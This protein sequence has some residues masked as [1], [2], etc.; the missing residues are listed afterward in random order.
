MKKKDYAVRVYLY[1]KCKLEE[2]ADRN[3]MYVQEI[4]ELLVENY[5]DALMDDYD[6]Q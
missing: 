2:V 3:G 1:D 5:L 6:L 4:I